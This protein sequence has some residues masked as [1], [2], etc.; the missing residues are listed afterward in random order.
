MKSEIKITGRLVLEIRKNGKTIKTIE[1]ENTVVSLGRQAV[2]QLLGGDVTDNSVT[3]FKA[4]TSTASTTV[5]MSD[6]GTP[7]NID[8]DQVKPIDSVTYPSQTSVRFN[9]TIGTS[10]A[11]GNALSELGLFT[12]NDDMVARK[13]FPAIDKTSDIEIV[14]LWTILFT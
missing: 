11:N 8:A 13:V 6:L 5:S 9:F 1:G 12:D 14:G 4:G 3:Y 2:A 7:V 10:E